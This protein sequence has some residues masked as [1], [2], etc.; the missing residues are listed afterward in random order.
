MP[1]ATFKKGE[2]DEWE[3]DTTCGIVL[4][5]CGYKLGMSSD[6]EDL[7]ENVF[8]VFEEGDDE[9]ETLACL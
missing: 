5:P 6:Y 8:A 1:K 2:Y 7:L 4:R 9:I 3:L